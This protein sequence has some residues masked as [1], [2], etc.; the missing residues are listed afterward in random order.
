MKPILF[1]FFILL[2]GILLPSFIKM[3]KQIQVVPFTEGF[4]KYTLE[5]ATSTFSNQMLPANPELRNDLLVENQ[6]PITGR[7]GISNNGADKIWWHYPIFTVGSYKQIT[8][9]IQHSRNPDEGTCT[10]A[11]MCGALYKNRKT[12]TNYVT[13]LP[14]INPTCGTRVGYFSTNMNLL[15]FRTDVPNI[16]Y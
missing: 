15:P 12:K 2:I 5:E 13:P 14:P 8:N 6:F 4:E 3:T 11:S 16:L 7:N 1:L 10:P 9:N